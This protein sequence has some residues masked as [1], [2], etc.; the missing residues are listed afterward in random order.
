MTNPILIVSPR[1]TPIGM[2]RMQLQ[3]MLLCACALLSVA[4]SR[5]ELA[6]VHFHP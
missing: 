1:L 4:P 2:H 3:R 6:P 5:D